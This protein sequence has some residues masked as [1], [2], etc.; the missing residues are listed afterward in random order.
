MEKKTSASGRLPS[1]NQQCGNVFTYIRADLVGGNEANIF[2]VPFSEEQDIYRPA[3]PKQR[4]YR[5]VPPWGNNSYRPVQPVQPRKQMFTVPSSRG[6][7]YLPSRP[8]EGKMLTVPSR[9]EILPRLFLP[10]R[11]VE[12]VCTRCPVPSTVYVPVS[13]TR[14]VVICIPPNK[15]IC[16]VP[17]RHDSQSL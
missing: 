14:P 13:P 4:H 9:H 8:D 16:P 15:L 10:S 5:P 6:K 2:T 3:S 12:T 11:P 1:R 7:Q 17:S